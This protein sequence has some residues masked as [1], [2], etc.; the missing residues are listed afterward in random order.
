MSK[1]YPIKNRLRRF[2]KSNK[3]TQKAVAGYLEM[4][5]TAQIS[6][7]ERGE[8]VPNLTQALRLSALYNRLV[9]DLFFDLFDEERRC[10][11]RKHSPDISSHGDTEC[12]EN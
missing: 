3:L 12:T 11:V 6:R 1:T 4:G 5:S 10:L 7:W 8:R 9:N 2:R